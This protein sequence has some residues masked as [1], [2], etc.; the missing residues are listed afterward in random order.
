VALDLL[1][2][3]TFVA[4]IEIVDLYSVVTDHW[5][6]PSLLYSFFVCSL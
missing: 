1:Q 5:C 3:E 2:H 4:P 6:V